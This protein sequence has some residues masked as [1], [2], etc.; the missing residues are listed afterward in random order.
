MNNDLQEDDDLCN[1][2]MDA[3]EQS[4]RAANVIQLADNVYVANISPGSSKLK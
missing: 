1:K 3:Y 2:A 4:Q